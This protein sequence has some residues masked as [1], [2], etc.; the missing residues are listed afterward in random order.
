MH[1]LLNRNQSHTE[2]ERFVD[3]KSHKIHLLAH[4]ALSQ[5]QMTVFPTLSYTSTSKIPTLNLSYTWSLEKVNR[6]GGASPYRPLWGVPPRTYQV[7]IN[8]I[9]L[10]PDWTKSSNVSDTL[11]NDLW[12]KIL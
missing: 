2:I 12:T 8:V 3:L 11:I 9:Y 1:C 6:S 5:T 4:W 10:I 7:H